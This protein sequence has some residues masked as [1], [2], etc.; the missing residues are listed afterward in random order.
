MSSNSNDKKS[1]LRILFTANGSCGCG[2]TK[3]IE[4]HEPTKIP[5]IPSTHHKKTT[6]N[7]TSSKAS[8]TTTSNDHN[9][10]AI[11]ISFDDEDEEFS[12]ATISDTETATTNKSLNHHHRHHVAPKQ[13]PL[14]NSVAVEKDSSDPYH[15]FRH[16]MLQMI[17]EKEIDSEEDL[18]DLLQCFLH[19]NAACYHHVIV[20]A[21][22]EICE[23]AFSDKVSTAPATTEPSP[24]HRNG[25][26][27]KGK[28]ERIG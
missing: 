14:L 17:F 1:V 24:S 18:Q 6:T 21:F 23:D 15:D 16:S 4:V 22:N 8:S 2:K 27:L 13:S 10:G 19:L 11:S 7:Q 25:H 3:A 20:K 9:G 12:S 28:S 26:F 5:K